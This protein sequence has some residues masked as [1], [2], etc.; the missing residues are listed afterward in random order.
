MPIKM[1]LEDKCMVIRGLGNQESVT[2]IGLCDCTGKRVTVIGI[3]D[4]MGKHVTVIGS[5]YCEG[6]QL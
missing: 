4:C 6:K 3:C 1:T 2:M 5:C